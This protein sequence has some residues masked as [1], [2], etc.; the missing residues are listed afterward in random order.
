LHDVPPAVHRG[1]NNRRL[2]LRRLG[3]GDGREGAGRGDAGGG[4]RL[5]GEW[6]EKELQ[7]PPTTTTSSSSTPEDDDRDGI[8][9]D[10]SPAMEMIEAVIAHPEE[11][12]ATTRVGG[13][14]S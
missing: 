5:G 9:V 11:D 7:F 2:R 4:E 1:D 14:S 13:T 12:V 3:R 6:K 10:E 8:R